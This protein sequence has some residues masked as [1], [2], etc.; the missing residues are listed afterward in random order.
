MAV[1]SIFIHLSA[2]GVAEISESP[3]LK[4][5]PHTF[6]FLVCFQYTCMYVFI[7]LNHCAASQLLH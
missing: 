5:C 6:V 3:N 2:T 7:Y 4:E 1:C